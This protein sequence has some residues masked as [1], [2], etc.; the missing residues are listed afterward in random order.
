MSEI[1]IGNLEVVLFFLKNCFF[2]ATFCNVRSYFYIF[3]KKVLYFGYKKLK[4]GWHDNIEMESGSYRWP[5]EYINAIHFISIE[6]SYLALIEGWMSTNPQVVLFPAGVLFSRTNTSES[7]RLG[8]VAPTWVDRTSRW[9][10]L[11]NYRSNWR[12]C[13]G[14]RT[15]LIMLCLCGQNRKKW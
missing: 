5:S 9:A 12:S 4:L 13:N 11:L 1:L 6:L 7:L 15:M 3:A 10:I 14:F 2:C 8:L